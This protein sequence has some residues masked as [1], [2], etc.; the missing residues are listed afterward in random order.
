MERSSN[1]QAALPQPCVPLSG[2]RDSSIL[3]VD[4]E[5]AVRELLVRLLQL[6]GHRVR[7]VGSAREAHAALKESPVTL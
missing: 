5:E 2:H 4:D 7:A 6:E 3:V 1:D